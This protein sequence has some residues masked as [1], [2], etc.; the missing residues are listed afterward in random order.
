MPWS[1]CRRKRGNGDDNCAL[2]DASGGPSALVLEGVVGTNS[3]DKG[4]LIKAAFLC[5]VLI[6]LWAGVYPL[7]TEWRCHRRFGRRERRR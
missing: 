5:F 6:L 4:M 1:G 7:W 2:T 3:P